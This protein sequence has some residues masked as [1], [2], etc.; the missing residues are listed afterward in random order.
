[1]TQGGTLDFLKIL[2]NKI[3]NNQGF[4]FRSKV[5][6][7]KLY[8]VIAVVPSPKNR[9]IIGT[10]SRADS[11]NLYVFVSCFHTNSFVIDRLIKPWKRRFHA[12]DK[13][14]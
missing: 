3:Q 10:T 7:L 4:S 13:V 5:T 1:M 11:W 12:R 14:L 9:T 8:F 6:D 2:K